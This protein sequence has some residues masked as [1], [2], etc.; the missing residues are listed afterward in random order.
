M[1]YNDFEDYMR[2]VLGYSTNA[3]NSINEQYQN[4]Y[5]T[6]YGSTYQTREL[7]FDIEQMYPKIYRTINPMVCN[8]CQNI[9]QPI[10]EELIEQMTNEIYRNIEKRVEIQN[11]VNLKIETRETECPENSEKCKENREFYECS[12]CKSFVNGK[13]RENTRNCGKNLVT[14]ISDNGIEKNISNSNQDKRSEN[15]LIQ[16]RQQQSQNQLLRDL[17]RILILNQLFRPERPPFI[18]GLGFPPSRPH[19]PLRPERPPF[20]PM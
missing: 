9:N 15:T 4:E 13:L 17:I 18:P 2:S 6:L 11:V 5:Q 1:L 19:M 3:S 16:Q 12:N 8:M 20:R 7:N 14:K 10:T